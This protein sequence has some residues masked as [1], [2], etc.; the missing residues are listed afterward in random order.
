MTDD[1]AQPLPLE[2]YW[3][4]PQCKSRVE[5]RDVTYEEYHDGCG[6][7]VVAITQQGIDAYAEVER[8]R[9]A[10][11][12]SEKRAGELEKQCD[13]YLQF[14]NHPVDWIASYKAICSKALT[15]L[16]GGMEMMARQELVKAIG[17]VP[18]KAE[19]PSPSEVP[20]EAKQEGTQG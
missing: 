19:A 5:G 1:T 9:G 18:P 6:G 12:A 14:L 11:A 8:L 4:C 13:H 17:F 2:E 7:A 15:Y 20:S 3:W 10:L 16:E